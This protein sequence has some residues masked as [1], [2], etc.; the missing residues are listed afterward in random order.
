M[1]DEVCYQSR[2]VSHGTEI[3]TGDDSEIIEQGNQVLGPEIATS[4]RGKR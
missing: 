1:T 3:D 4:T 2:R